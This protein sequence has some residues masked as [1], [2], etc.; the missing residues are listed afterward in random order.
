MEGTDPHPRVEGVHR[1]STRLRGGTKRNGE[2]LV[3]LTDQLLSWTYGA[4][5]RV[6]RIRQN[7]EEP[8]SEVN[9]DEDQPVELRRS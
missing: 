6:L 4:N 8:P 7:Q 3:R 1:Q 2:H 9:V 5:D